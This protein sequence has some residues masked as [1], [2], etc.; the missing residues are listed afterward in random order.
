MNISIIGTGYVGLVSGACFAKFGHNVRCV[1]N[2]TEKIKKIN[3]STSP[4]YEQGLDDLLTNFKKNIIA[5]TDLKT[6]I[7]KTEITF[8][9][10]GTPSKEDG[11]IDLSTVKEVAIQIGEN[12]KNKKKWH[13]VVVKSTVTPGTTINEIL[14]ILEKYSGKKAGK[15]FGLAMNPEFLR[16][17]TAI[18]DFLEPDRIIYGYYDE[19]TKNIM[20]ALYKDLLR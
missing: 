13:L 18:K 2:D 7:E 5:T 10:V 6:S 20:D 1:D 17:G 11:D 8:I 14:P 12:L 19:K 9:C 3:N 15:N 16:E 4:I